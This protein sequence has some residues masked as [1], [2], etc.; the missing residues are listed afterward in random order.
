MWT[1]LAIGY[2]KVMLRM[3][4]RTRDRGSGTTSKEKW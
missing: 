2:V 3:E 1:R 4:P